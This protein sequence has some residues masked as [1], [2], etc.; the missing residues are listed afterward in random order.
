MK[1]YTIENDIDYAAVPSSATDAEM[2]AH[3]R[4][5]STEAEFARLASEWPTSRLMRSWNA[6]PGVVPVRSLTSRRLAVARIWNYVQTLD[7]T[8]RNQMSDTTDAP[9]CLR[10]PGSPAASSAFGGSPHSHGRKR[11]SDCRSGGSMA[12]VIVALL[13]QPGGATLDSIKQATGWQAHSVR[14][15]ISGTARRKLNLNVVSARD[16]NGARIYRVEM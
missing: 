7:S 1:S 2:V 3:I 13:R 10:M 9:G 8:G 11:N 5:F 12:D 16:A 15:F 6:L 4:R 14:G